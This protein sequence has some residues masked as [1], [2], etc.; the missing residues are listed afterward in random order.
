MNHAEAGTEGAPGVRPVFSLRGTGGDG[1][2][3]SIPRAVSRRGIDRA[4]LWRASS[5]TASP[6]GSG[7]GGSTPRWR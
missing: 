5:A 7:F 4:A 2:Q 1:N 6:D 3:L